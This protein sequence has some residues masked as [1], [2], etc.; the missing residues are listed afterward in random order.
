[1][2]WGSVAAAPSGGMNRIRDIRSGAVREIQ[3]DSTPRY[4]AID[5]SERIR[6]KL[7]VRG[8]EGFF[9]EL[10][11]ASFDFFLRDHALVDQKRYSGD[12]D[13]AL[14]HA[15]MSERCEGFFVHYCLIAL[16]DFRSLSVRCTG[17]LKVFRTG[18]Q[19]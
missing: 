7:I 5:Q 17:S 18:T 12:R 14:Y 6:C 8:A 1:M 9:A 16:D 15:H 11:D 4:G 2:N 3:V 19:I 10:P 13:R